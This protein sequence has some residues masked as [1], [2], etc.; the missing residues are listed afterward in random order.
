M[1]GVPGIINLHLSP[2]Q[3]GLLAFTH[4]L[5]DHVMDEPDCLV[6]HAQLPDQGQRGN[7]SLGLSDS[8]ESKEPGGQWH[9]CCGFV[10]MDTA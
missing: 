3:I 5:H 4:C 7:A 8:I 6:V 9:R 10:D 1:N 2:Q